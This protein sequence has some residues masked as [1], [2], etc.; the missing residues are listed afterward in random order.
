MK[1]RGLYNKYHIEKMNGD[2]V[3]SRANYFVL[4]LDN[5]GKDKAHISACRKAVLCYAEAIKDH[6]PLLAKDL[7]K[8]YGEP[9][10]KSCEGCEYDETLG[11][12]SNKNLAMP[13]NECVKLNH[14][15]YQPKQ[16]EGEG[17]LAPSAGYC[18]EIVPIPD[19][20]KIL[21][22]LDVRITKLEVSNKTQDIV[23]RS[24]ADATEKQV[25]INES[26]HKWPVAFEGKDYMPL[27]EA[28]VDHIGHLQVH[29]FYT[30]NIKKSC[31]VIKAELAKLR[32]GK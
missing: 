29:P 30:E 22:D 11:T 16:A 5:Y 26:C 3:D 1:E 31:V 8:K 13:Y 24:I 19:H 23:N 7:I 21:I 20:A 27:L 32:S 10:A 2:N 18:G 6:L 17:I 25:E 4:R 9:V 12:C 28:I 15:F 14:K